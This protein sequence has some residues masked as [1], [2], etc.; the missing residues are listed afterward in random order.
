[1]SSCVQ[2][3]IS[4]GKSKKKNKNKKKTKLSLYLTN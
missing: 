1:M 3:I 4:D 2:N